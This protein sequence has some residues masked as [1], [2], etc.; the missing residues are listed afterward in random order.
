ML[1]TIQRLKL[2]LGLFLTDYI[3]VMV[4]YKVVKTAITCSPIITHF[5][6][7]QLPLYQIIKSHSI[8]PSKYNCLEVL[9]TGIKGQY[10]VF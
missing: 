7:I 4:T 9:E 10:E 2:N 1:I 5:C 6:L 8:D 3:V